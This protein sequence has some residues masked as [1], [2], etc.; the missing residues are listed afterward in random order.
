MRKRIVDT[1]D[2][3]SPTP[4]SFYTEVINHQGTLRCAMQRGRAGPRTMNRIHT[5]NRSVVSSVM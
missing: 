4:A 5:L 3:L 1:I 2:R